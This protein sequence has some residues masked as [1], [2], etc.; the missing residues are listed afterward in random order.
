MPSIPI[1]GW[2]ALA[3][4]VTIG[5]VASIL[6]LRETESPAPLEQLERAQKKGAQAQASGA[7]IASNLD[8]IAGHIEAGQDLSKETDAIHRLTA[9]QRRSLVDVLNLLRGQLDSLGRTRTTLSELQG[10]AA[11]LARLGARQKAVIAESVEALR[12]LDRFARRAA[13]TSATF[14]RNAVYGARLAEDSSQRFSP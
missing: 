5:A 10:S 8:R 2:I 6:V 13:V 4:V 3:L 1:K 14:A 11:A 7:D 12:E 9:R